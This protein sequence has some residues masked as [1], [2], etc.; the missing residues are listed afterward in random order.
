MQQC[1][2]LLFFKFNALFWLNVPSQSELNFFLNP[3]H[4]LFWTKLYS[5]LKNAY[6]LSLSSV[7]LVDWNVI[8]LHK[9]ADKIAVLLKREWKI[10]VLQAK[11]F[12]NSVMI[13]QA[14]RS[15]KGIF[16]WV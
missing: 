4:I 13:L 12:E 15:L 9:L 11:S 5:Y 7:H 14:L 10:N 3:Q 1:L 16:V 6:G 8:Q 2:F